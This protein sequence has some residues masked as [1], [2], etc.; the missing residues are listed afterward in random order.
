MSVLAL[1]NGIGRLLCG[2]ATKYPDFACAIQ[3]TTCSIGTVCIFLLPHCTTTLQFYVVMG[4]YGLVIAPLVV[5]NTTAMVN[6]VGMSGLSTAYGITETIYG[7]ANVAGPTLI[8]MAHDYF[9][10]YQIPF[11]LAGC[12]FG[13]GVVISFVTSKVY[14]GQKY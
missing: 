6:M 5:L 7:I 9:K 10:N 11:Y 3:G 13:A 8:G 1:A 12:C 4:V 2:L 14:F